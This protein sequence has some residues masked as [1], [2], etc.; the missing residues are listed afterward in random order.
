[1][2]NIIRFNVVH[3]DGNVT[4]DGNNPIFREQSM[5]QV[6]EQWLPLTR[7]F[8]NIFIKNFTSIPEILLNRLTNQ[9]LH[10]A[11]IIIDTPK[12]KFTKSYRVSRPSKFYAYK[13]VPFEF[14]KCPKSLANFT[15]TYEFQLPNG[16]T[17]STTTNVLAEL[18]KLT[19]TKFLPNHLWKAFDEYSQSQINKCR[20][21]NKGNYTFAEDWFKALTKDC[22]QHHIKVSSPCEKTYYEAMAELDFE[23]QYEVLP[24]GL[25]PLNDEELAFLYKYAPA[26]GVDIPKFQW[27]INTRQTAHGYTEEPE[28]VYYGATQ[29]DYNRMIFDPKNPNNLPKFARQNLAIKSYDND[30]LLRDS[31]TTLK[32]LMKHL[33]DSALM[34]EYKRCPKCHS[35][36]HE[37]IGCDCGYCKPVEFVQADNLFY[38]N[39][40]TYEDIDA[41]KDTYL[42]LINELGQDE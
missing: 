25:R 26:Y 29:T 42:E 35:I 10:G 32:W 14:D 4:I 9:Y 17:A 2:K 16:Q 33:K 3:N 38:G 39:A 22:I 7:L 24:E 19:S 23:K 41:T 20:E 6:L 34:P 31:Y 28:R 8:K 36:Y 27:R 40:S 15:Y 13:W 18:S 12:C 21:F 5:E 11:E 37:N 1:M 30:K